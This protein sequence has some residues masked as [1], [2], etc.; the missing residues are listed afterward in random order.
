MFKNKSCEYLA[1]LLNCLCVY[2]H[3]LCVYM[4]H[5]YLWYFKDRISEK[6]AKKCIMMRFY[7]KTMKVFKMFGML[8][9]VYVS[10]YT[11]L[12]AVFLDAVNS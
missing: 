12:D 5:E 10:R 7:H 4:S 1:N 9:L 2:M 6:I 11:F 8:Q 3:N